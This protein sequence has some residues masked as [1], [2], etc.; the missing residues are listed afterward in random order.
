MA[1]PTITFRT[2]ATDEEVPRLI[3]SA[4]GFVFASYEDFGITPIE[5]LATGT[6][7]IAYH[8]GGARDY[9]IPE[10]TGQFFA[11]QTVESL[12]E[13][14]QSFDPTIYD[15]TELIDQAKRFSKTT[16]REKLSHY[17]EEKL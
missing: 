8:A 15:P 10:K 7:V 3:A 11:E 9:V 16:F 5:A 17:I 14:L 6:P 12:V 2:D 1:G 13:A 4:T